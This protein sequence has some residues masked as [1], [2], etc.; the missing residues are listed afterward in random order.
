MGS[1]ISS[2]PKRDYQNLESSIEKNHFSEIPEINQNQRKMRK[3]E[4]YLQ[5][6]YLYFKY[7]QLPTP[8]LPID[9]EN[10]FNGSYAL[11]YH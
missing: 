6:Q 3:I 10:H 5:V 8:V 1:G 9:N 4:N 7:Q 2:G 11:Y